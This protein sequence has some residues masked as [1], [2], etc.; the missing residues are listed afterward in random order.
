M[1]KVTFRCKRSGNTVSFSNEADVA[2]M[3]KDLGYDEVKESG[4][5]LQIQEDKT[6]PEAVE[7]PRK[8]RG[9]PRT[10]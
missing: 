3:R 1:V 4:N 5:G 6:T 8:T 2:T 7:L 9:R 10:K